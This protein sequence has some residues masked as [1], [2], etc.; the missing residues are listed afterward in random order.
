M[1]HNRQLMLKLNSS[2]TK[3][4]TPTDFRIHNKIHV[5]M[6]DDLR[7]KQGNTLTHITFTS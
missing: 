7:G 2:A 1:K 3:L 5:K 6:I 4:F